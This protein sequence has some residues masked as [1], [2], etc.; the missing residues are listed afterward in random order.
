METKSLPSLSISLASWNSSE[1]ETVQQ[2]TK[3]TSLPCQHSTGR[4]KRQAKGG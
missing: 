2:S 1:A 3:I 4:E